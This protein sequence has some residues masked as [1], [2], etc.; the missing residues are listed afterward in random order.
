[1]LIRI[2]LRMLKLFYLAFNRSEDEDVERQV[3]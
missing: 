1:M 3:Q 2:S